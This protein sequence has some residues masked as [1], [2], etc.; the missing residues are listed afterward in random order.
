M[1]EIEN[2]TISADMDLGSR[3]F[4]IVTEDDMFQVLIE[5]DVNRLPEESD[6]IESEESRAL[7]MLERGLLLQGETD[8]ATVATVSVK[9]YYTPQARR[10]TSN[11]Q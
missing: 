4:E 8:R 5:I 3:S 10:S 9:V 11:I 2:D 7:T 6:P 1:L